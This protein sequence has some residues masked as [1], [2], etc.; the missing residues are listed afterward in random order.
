MLPVAVL[1][2]TACE[3]YDNSQSNPLDVAESSIPGMVFSP[4]NRTGVGVGSAAEFELFAVEA[5]G[6][7]AIHAQ[8]SYNESELTVTNVTP[9]TFFEDNSAAQSSFF[10]YDDLPGK[11]DIYYFYMGSDVTKDGTGSIA[12]VLFSTKVSFEESILELT[13]ESEFVD[14]DDSAIQVNTLGTAKI[15]Q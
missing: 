2:S 14:A 8:I 7:S 9:G 15:I 10:V 4:D 1:F 11:L 12:K 13:Q 5:T 6:V 3:L